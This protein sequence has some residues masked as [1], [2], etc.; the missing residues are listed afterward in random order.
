MQ[1]SWPN[2][3]YEGKKEDWLIY[4]PRHLA[5]ALIT[6]LFEVFYYKFFIKTSIDIPLF[7]TN[8]A[9]TMAYLI[10]FF[11]KITNDDIRELDI[12][13]GKV[14]VN[15]IIYITKLIFEWSS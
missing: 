4:S 10:F 14:W 8:L 15:N 9:R 6:F 1:V 12:E 2:N 3:N 5:T 11:T 13:E 7:I